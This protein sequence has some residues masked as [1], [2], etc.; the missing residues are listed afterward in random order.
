M[1]GLTE[2]GAVTVLVAGT[3][4][5]AGLMDRQEQAAET[6]LEAKTDR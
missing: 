3:V 5:V 1:G 6:L 4:V 2:A